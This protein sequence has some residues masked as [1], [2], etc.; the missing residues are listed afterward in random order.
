MQ[1]VSINVSSVK[2]VDDGRREFTTGIFKTPISERVMVRTLNID[3]D[4]QADLQA[5]GGPYKAV[6]AYSLENYQ[7]WLKE[8][9]QEYPPG[10]FGENLTL[11]AGLETD[12][13][14]GDIFEVGGA[15]LQVTQPRVP[16]FK[17]AHKMGDPGFVKKFMVAKRTGFYLRVVQEGEIGVGDEMRRTATDPNGVSVHG[18]FHLLYF[19]SSD[20]EMAQRALNIESLSPG[21]RG[22]MEEILAS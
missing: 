20:K 22:S 16:C 19:D 12:I 18:I 17:L 8:I 1:V 11:D 13:F 9:G 21:W 2:T 14:V 15:I 3:G 4:K 7:F 10:Q 5:H 6:Y